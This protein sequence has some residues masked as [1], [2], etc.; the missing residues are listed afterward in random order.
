MHTASECCMCVYGFNSVSVD[1]AFYIIIHMYMYTTVTPQS[2]PHID[3]H[4]HHS[5]DLYC[6]TAPSVLILFPAGVHWRG[7]PSFCPWKTGCTI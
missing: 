2:I 4:V 6:V 3:I 7:V 5:Y 1:K